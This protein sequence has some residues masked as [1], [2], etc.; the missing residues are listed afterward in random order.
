[1]DGPHSIEHCARI[2]EEVLA[3]VYKALSDNHVMLEVSAAALP[4]RQLHMCLRH[5]QKE[6][7]TVCTNL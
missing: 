1:M 4:C 2:T 7:I 6:K 5:T 3:A